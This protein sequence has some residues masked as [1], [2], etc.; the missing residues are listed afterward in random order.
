MKRHAI[1]TVGALVLAT[2]VVE[3]QPMPGPAMYNA[4][5]GQQG[6][7]AMQA[8]RRNKMS[9]TIGAPQPVK[10]TANAGTLF[11]YQYVVPLEGSAYAIRIGLMNPYT[12]L[13][14]IN[15]VGIYPSDTYGGFLVN[16][17]NQTSGKVTGIPTANTVFQQCTLTN[18]STSVTG[19]VNTALLPSGSTMY[20][21]NV[22]GLPAQV[23]ATV[24]TGTTL[25][26]SSAFTGTT[27]QYNVQFSNLAAECK[28]YWDYG[29][30]DVDTVNTAGVLRTV[31]FSG[32][33]ASNPAPYTVQHGDLV[34]CTTVPRA[35]IAQG[36]TPA[37]T[38]Q[39]NLV[40]VFVT[41]A[42]AN[43]AFGEAPLGPN[44][45]NTN[46]APALGNRYII[47]G[48]PWSNG[49]VDYADN[50]TGSGWTSADG[51]SG[52]NVPALSV[53]YM[54]TQPGWNMLQDGDSLSVA[55]GAGA[56]ALGG[57]GSIETPEW[58]A[59]K[60]LSTPSA[61]CESANFAWGGQAFAVYGETMRQNMAAFQPSFIIA[62]PMTRNE[63]GGATLAAYQKVVSMVYSYTNA[64]VR[65][66]PPKLAFRGALPF[67]TTIDG[68]SSLI[69]QW[70]TM[71][72][73]VN[74]LGV[75]CTPSVGSSLCPAT[76][77]YDPIPLTG[78][79]AYAGG[80]AYD[81]PS[82]DF[83]ANGACAAAAT[84]CNVSAN[85]VNPCYTTDV[86]SDL[87]NP[88][89]ISAANAAI[90]G[91]TSTTISVGASAIIGGGIQ[92][93]DHLV[94]SIPGY[95]GA[96]LSSDNTHPNYNGVA[97]LRAAALAFLKQITGA[98]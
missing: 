63:P 92:N 83:L 64:S 32:T 60:L 48:R 5:A 38:A 62:Q 89:V 44:A 15:S 43:V 80:Q 57:G 45:Y 23:T 10:S 25:T 69:S 86:L 88:G 42:V 11:T 53:T 22:A 39:T 87:T 73:V 94:C 46:T 17:V 52:A 65:A 36:V 97:V 82:R 14:A 16:N 61:P 49:G 40:F 3:A 79:A 18:N 81:Y 66:L 93:G 95:T 59:C 72:A 98:P 71:R 41:L 34:P 7:Y 56:N 84:T 58:Q 85:S 50:P 4:V 35:D 33:S 28:E 77:T 8:P 96:P 21:M 70:N 24:A 2:G 19:C 20:A 78:A 27:G 76:P 12:S 67:T 6:A 9:L 37:G 75:G 47:E 68:N 1:A 90:T 55:P 74:G 30:A 13:M 91:S 31:S 51:G 26:L 29:G 54:T